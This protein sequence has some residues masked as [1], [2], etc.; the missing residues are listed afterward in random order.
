MYMYL[1][2]YNGHIIYTNMYMCACVCV[3]MSL[4]NAISLNRHL[5]ISLKRCCRKLILVNI[6]QPM[7]KLVLLWVL[8]L[9]IAEPIDNIKDLLYVDI[10]QNLKMAKAGTVERKET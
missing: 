6:N 1:Y 4:N 10:L 8:L 2:M 3:Y 7:L 9:K 5:I